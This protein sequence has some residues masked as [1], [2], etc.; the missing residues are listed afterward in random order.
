[1]QELGQLP[2][3]LDVQ[4]VVAGG[5][6]LHPDVG[7]S[8]PGRL[9]P[10][11]RGPLVTAVEI[12]EPPVSPWANVKLVGLALIE[13]S[14]NGGAAQ[15]GNLNDAILVLQLNAPVLGMYSCV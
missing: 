1:M 14:F 15:P 10:L 11:G 9:L 7:P 12:V 2:G 4:V 8:G 3:V 5:E 13:K 6:P